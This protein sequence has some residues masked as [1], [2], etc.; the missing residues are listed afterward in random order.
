MFVNAPAGYLCPDFM[1]FC[2]SVNGP[3]ALV[4]AKPELPVFSGALFVFCNKTRDK[5]TL[6]Y[7]DPTRFALWYKH[8]DKQKFKWLKQQASA[9]NLMEEQL[10]W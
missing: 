5:L 2:Q 6:L 3:A 4:D 8:L 10:R 1:D 7:G 9:L